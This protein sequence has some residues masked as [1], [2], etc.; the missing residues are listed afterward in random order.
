MKV[1]TMSQILKAESEWNQSEF[2]N[3][4]QRL[5]LFGNKLF[6]CIQKFISPCDTVCM[7]IGSGGN[8]TDGIQLAIKLINSGY[9]VYIWQCF[10]HMQMT[11]HQSDFFS[12]HQDVIHKQPPEEHYNILIDAVTGTGYIP[13]D[14]AN[15]NSV[16]SWI[17][18]HPSHQVIS[19]DLP[20]GIHPHGNHNQQCV[21][22]DKLMTLHGVKVG[23]L[24][25]NALDQIKV[26][27]IL[28]SD[29]SNEIEYYKC[30][31]T[32]SLNK[33]SQNFHKG[34]AG[35]VVCIGGDK[36]MEGAGILSSIAALRSGAG[37][38]HYLYL[39]EP[40]FFKIDPSLMVNEF[41]FQTLKL[42][43]QKRTICIIGPGIGRSDRA[44]KVIHHLMNKDVVRVF[45]ADALY[46]LDSSMNFNP[47]DV[48]TPHYKEASI[49]LNKD[50]EEIKSNPLNAALDLYDLFK[51]NIVLKGPV[52][53]F[54][55]N[56]K[57]TF[58]NVGN[59]SLSTAGT[60][61]ILAGLIG[62]FIAQFGSSDS[63]IINAILTHGYASQLVDQEFGVGLIA[64]DLLKAIARTIK[65]HTS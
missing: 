25:G 40:K 29:Q 49:L 8:G 54:V 12:N 65:C 46:F 53:I 7:I 27:N 62:G 13:S 17:N 57:P 32:L 51:I 11:K 33:R 26:I 21:Q 5:E 37:Y 59:S 16:I 31:D 34:N 50:I 2:T 18:R 41:D 36:G 43:L 9:H 58:I 28:E 63:S 35:R 48:M 45:D 61:D 1:F 6:D 19:I 39:S 15:L 42:L 3:Y 60:G 64:S 22:C 23:C 10:E 24:I 44:K 38:S 56:A 14:N 20:S 47:K 4:N 52:S 55:N 30:I